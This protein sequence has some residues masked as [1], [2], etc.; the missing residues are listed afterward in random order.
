MGEIRVGVFLENY[1]DLLLKKIG[2]LGRKKVRS[3]RVEAVA[4]TGAVMMLLSED[5]VEGL[6]LEK[7]D[8]A[9]VTLANEQKV[10][11]GIAGTLRVSVAGRHWETDC[12]IG[13]PQCE[14]L[15][16][17]L[18]MERL[19]LIA[20][21]LRQTVTPRPESPFLPSLKLK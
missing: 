21:P 19:D 16:G 5:L 11:L 10:E 8:K 6:G 7:K 15:L 4:D 13:P 20:D 17:Q 1:E 12:L 14:P 9:I 2:K 3:A 18:V